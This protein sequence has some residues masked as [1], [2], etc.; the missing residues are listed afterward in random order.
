MSNAHHHDDKAHD[1]AFVRTFGMVMAALGSIFAF[2]IFAASF[3]VPKSG[4]PKAEAARVEA[5]IKPVGV[6]VTSA[7][8]LAKLSPPPVKR[9]PM[10]AEAIFGQGCG[11]CHNA[12]L[13]NAPK[14]SDKAEW[15]K[16]L[17]A[18]GG[19][20]ALAGNAIAGKNQMPARGGNADLSDD[21][22]KAT[23]KLMLQKAGL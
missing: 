10:T 1:K 21:E 23:V 11:G 12:G 20:D 16:R 15:S 22:V 5:R 18:A 17:A 19:F 13:L 6:V 9:E 14:I 3:I 4:D 8:E 2:C 7:E